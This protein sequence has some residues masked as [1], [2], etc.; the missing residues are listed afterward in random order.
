MFHLKTELYLF[1]ILGVFLFPSMQARSGIKSQLLPIASDTLSYIELGSLK[2][3]TLT[4]R[5]AIDL[6][7]KNA[8]FLKV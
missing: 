8:S 1:F 7:G 4:I 5:D 2:K 3:K 6:D